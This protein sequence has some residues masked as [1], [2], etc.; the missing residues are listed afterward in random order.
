MLSPL[1]VW[2]DGAKARVVV[3]YKDIS[4]L[5]C[6]LMLHRSHT[7]PSGAHITQ[8]SERSGTTSFACC[9]AA[10]TPCGTYLFQQK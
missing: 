6:A 2:L 3:G 10:H 4:I 7:A 1:K 5:Q 9:L 8:S